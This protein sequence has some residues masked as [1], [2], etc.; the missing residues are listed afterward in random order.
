MSNLELEITLRM[1][2]HIPFLPSNYTPGTPIYQQNFVDLRLVEAG[3]VIEA[4]EHASDFN[5]R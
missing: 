1:S 4:H 5:V 3:N 2:G